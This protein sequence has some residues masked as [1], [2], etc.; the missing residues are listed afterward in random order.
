MNPNVVVFPKKKRQSVPKSDV[1]LANDVRRLLRK[2]RR[3]VE[4]ASD[5][6]VSVAF[7]IEVSPGVARNIIRVEEPKFTRSF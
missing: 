4:A 5:A 7:T 6:G 1:D 3:T 2:L